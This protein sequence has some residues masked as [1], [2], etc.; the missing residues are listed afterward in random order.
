MQYKI[1]VDLE[2][3]D[4]EDALT[5][6]ID[7]RMYITVDFYVHVILINTLRADSEPKLAIWRV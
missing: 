4:K 5:T 3:K 7:S 6:I 2:M 1:H